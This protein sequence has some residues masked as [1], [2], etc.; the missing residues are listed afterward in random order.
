MKKKRFTEEQIVRIL[1]E[2]ESGRK[3]SDICREYGVS[4]PTFYSW[5][6]KYEGLQVNQLKRLKDLEVENKK[7]KR[8]YAEAMMDNEALKDVLSK[9]W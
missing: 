6:K 2:A 8:M 3:V 9:K 7:L 4:S 1:K 5:R